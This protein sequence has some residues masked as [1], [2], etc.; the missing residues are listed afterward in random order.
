[1]RAQGRGYPYAMRAIFTIYV[2]VIAVGILA[3]VLAAATET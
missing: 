2:V 1:L 3:A